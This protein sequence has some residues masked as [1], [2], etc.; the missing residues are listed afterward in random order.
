MLQIIRVE[1]A[2]EKNGA[3]GLVSMFPSWVVVLK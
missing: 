2:N 3:I 1:K